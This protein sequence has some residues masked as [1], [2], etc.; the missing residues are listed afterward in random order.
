MNGMDPI[1]PADAVMCL[2]SDLELDDDGYPMW[3]DG[4]M[5]FVAEEIA[6]YRNW[7]KT[8]WQTRCTDTRPLRSG[9]KVMNRRC[10]GI[11]ICSG[12]HCVFVGR[13]PIITPACS[14]RVD[15]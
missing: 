7:G 5:V 9:I 8:K 2:P 4:H 1:N 3:P 6:A 10:L 11:L 14:A 15:Q 13:P 12:E